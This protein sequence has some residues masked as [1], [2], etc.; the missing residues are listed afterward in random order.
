MNYD[1]FTKEELQAIL[2]RYN[3]MNNT[4]RKGVGYC[5]YSSNHQQELSIEAQQRA[6][7]DY[8]LSHNIEITE[9]YID[10]AVSGQTDDRPAFKRLLKDTEKGNIKM[11]IVHK[12]DRFSRN[13]ADTFSY[14]YYFDDNNI[15]LLSVT[16]DFGDDDLMFGI[17]AVLNQRYVKN[18]SKEVM[19][20]LKER[21]YKCL[22][23]GGKPPLGY[24][25]EDDKY[26]IDESEAIIV[27]EIFNLAAEGY[28]YNKIIQILNKKGYKTKRGNSFGKNSIYELLRNEKYKG[29]YIFNKTAKRNSKKKRN[30]HKLKDESEI[31]R[32]DGGCPAIVSTD[33]WERANASRKMTA[34]VTTGAKFNYLLTGLVFCGECGSKMHGNP[35][36]Y[37][38]RKYN[39]YKCNKRGNKFECNCKEIRSDILENFVIDNLLKYFF[40]EEIIDKITEQINQKIREIA[41]TDSEDIAFAKK[42]LQ[43]LKSS[44]SNLVDAIAQ[45]GIT[46]TLSERLESIEKQISEYEEMIESEKARRKGFSV[47]K[48]QVKEK[49]GKLKDYFNNPKYIDLTKILLREYIEKVEVNNSTIKV[50]LKVAFSFCIDEKEQRISYNDTISYGRKGI[51]EYESELFTSPEKIGA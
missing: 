41:Q 12:L 42:S 11:I 6:I 39:T 44:R 10:R 43:G 35:R 45:T 18:L 24:K 50:T 1:N 4:T 7:K 32:I 8:C 49:I 13:V 31:I 48:K 36:Q 2:C 14:K 28:G 9:W 38:K 23:N 46:K 3:I 27:R 40:N 16:E 22:F 5:R 29:I 15:E 25:I 30:S 19:K 26:V 47:T 21:G 17:N 33:L 51:I 20:G 34:K 37:G